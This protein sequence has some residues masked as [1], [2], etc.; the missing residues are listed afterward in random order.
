MKQ[1]LKKQNKNE[2]QGSELYQIPMKTRNFNEL[3]TK[4]ILFA[5]LVLGL[6]FTSCDDDD[7]Y[8]VPSNKITTI[9]VP[10]SGFNQ[11]NVSDMFKVYVTFSEDEESVLVES[12]ENVHP[13]IDIKTQGDQLQIGL[14]KNTKFS[15]TPVL[16]VYI[17]TKSIDRIMAMGASYIEYQNPLESNSFEINLEGACIFKGHL[18]VD[19][20]DA[21]ITGA[22][23]LDL[24]GNSKE[25]NIRA[26][27]ASLMT[28]FNF[29]TENLNASVYGAS[30]IT[31][32]VNQKLNVTA[33]GASNVLY[34][35]NGTI[36]Y[37]KLSDVSKIVHVD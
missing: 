16:N 32:T 21:I 26:E 12:N 4:T 33:S 19:E 7:L 23:T 2:I 22:S 37:Q 31:L 36:E 24:T 27:G 5:F 17:K 34:K 8:L 15:G 35:G 25:L 29:E 13:S 28:G 9:E 1:A 11:L 14:Y 30:N 6:F 10:A 18:E 20:M 3:K